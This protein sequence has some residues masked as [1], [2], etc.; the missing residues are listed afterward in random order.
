MEEF[1]PDNWTEILRENCS[2]GSKSLEWIKKNA[3]FYILSYSDKSAHAILWKIKDTDGKGWSGVRMKREY[4]NKKGYY[5]DFNPI[6]IDVD[7]AINVDNEKRNDITS[8]F[9]EALELANLH[10]N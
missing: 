5:M 6:Y 3:K 7:W 10:T 1:R 4:E 9:N 8:D 2:N